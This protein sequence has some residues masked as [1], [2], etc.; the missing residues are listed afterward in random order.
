MPP[1]VLLLCGNASQVG[2]TT[3]VLGLTCALRKLGLK[4]RVAKA[5]PDF[6]DARYHALGSGASVANVDPWMLG[7][8]GLKRLWARI[9]AYDFDLLLLEGAMGLFDGGAASQAHLALALDLPILLLL[10]AKGQAESACALAE[11]FLWHA[12]TFY[13][14]L[15]I[16]GTV[17]SFVGAEK[18]Q[19]LL[20]Q[21]YAQGPLKFFK[22][23]LLGFLPRKGAPQIPSRHLGLVGAEEGLA[24]IEEEAL[25]P[26]FKS[27]FKIENLLKLLQLTPQRQDQVQ[28]LF[29][30]KFT[31]EKYFFDFKFAKEDNEDKEDKGDKSDKDSKEKSLPAKE[32]F[33]R[34][35]R[36]CVVVKKSALTLGLA[37]DEAFS[38]CYADLPAVLADYGLR[39][40]F[41]SPLKDP[42]PPLCSAYYFPG[43]YPELYAKELAAN[44]SMRSAF[45]ELFLAEVPI[46]GE[47]GGLIYLVDELALTDGQIYPMLGL[48]PGR[49]R[50]KANFQALG[51]RSA[52]A[53]GWPSAKSL[54][55]RGHEFH[56]AC[57]EG[58]CQAKPLWRVFDFKGQPLGYQG[59][60]Q[61]N[62]AA[63]WL[64]LSPEG[65][66]GFWRE[67]TKLIVR[68]AHGLADK[69]RA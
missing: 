54:L 21:A 17:F 36:V 69:N 20:T 58:D 41:F 32:G 52:L 22:T 24:A 57:L 4:V 62:C 12:K 25:L 16:L 10:D 29:S 2:K 51:Y 40:V 31:K 44:S 59:L 13:P 34:S 39:T 50:L 47:C 37:F 38:F 15:K 6:I 8:C 48:L 19:L 67:W 63:S 23:P 68:C 9:F 53:L 42:K 7:R 1:K 65:G 33:K 28:D 18:H 64:H 35:G 11:G 14:K 49:A 27:S 61:G 45:K 43:G 5:G 3:C 55:V 56:Y 46:Y 26:W 30:A 60:R 66:R